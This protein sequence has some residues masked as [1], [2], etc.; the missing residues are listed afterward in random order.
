M[1]DDAGTLK[2]SHCCLAHSGLHVDIRKLGV[3]AEC[4]RPAVG[5]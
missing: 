3:P 5:E 4:K 1:L 2:F